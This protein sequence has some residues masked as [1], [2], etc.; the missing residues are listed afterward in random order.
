MCRCI[1][2]WVVRNRGG[3]QL[4]VVLFLAGDLSLFSSQIVKLTNAMTH[5]TLLVGLVSLRGRCRLAYRNEIILDGKMY[6]ILI[7]SSLQR[8]LKKR[9]RRRKIFL[10]KD[11]VGAAIDA[12]LTV[13]SP[14]H[15]SSVPLSK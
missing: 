14:T 6:I 13:V 5:C 3:D 2:E 10:P 15:R 7:I 8:F 4:N 1:E 9:D 11:L 12:A